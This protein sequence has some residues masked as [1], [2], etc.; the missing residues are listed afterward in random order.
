M[1]GRCWP[2]HRSGPGRARGLHRQRC[3]TESPLPSGR[4]VVSWVWPVGGLAVVALVGLVAGLVGLIAGA[5]KPTKG[6]AVPTKFRVAS[7]ATDTPR[8][9]TM[10][11]PTHTPTPSL[12]PTCTEKP[13]PAPSHTPTRRLPDDMGGC[14]VFARKSVLRSN[15]PSEIRVLN[16]ETDAL[17]QLTHINAVDRIPS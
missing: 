3:T 11:R 7:R 8:P 6:T 16:L 15:N 9:P 1:W 2:V 5:W 4:R 13:T 12:S 10:L 17:N 14:I